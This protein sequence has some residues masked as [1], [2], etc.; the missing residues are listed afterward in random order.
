MTSY[1][2][3]KSHCG[4]KTIL[5]PSYLHNGI[6]YT[7]KMTSLYWIRAKM[8]MRLSYCY[9]WIP[10]LLRQNLYIETRCRALIWYKDCLTN[11]ITLWQMVV[12]SSYLHKNSY[13]RKTA[14]LYQTSPQVPYCTYFHTNWPK[15]LINWF[16]PA[17][18]TT[19]A[20]HNHP[21]CWK[22]YERHSAMHHMWHLK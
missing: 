17:F 4:D 20:L 6:S 7:G 12:R 5:R 1:Q 15:I 2:N 11:I 22:S 19:H 3:R 21:S 9:N 16:W 10:I 18:P 8:V 13:T 14:C